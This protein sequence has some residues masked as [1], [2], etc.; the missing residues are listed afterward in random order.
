MNSPDTPTPDPW[1]N[2]RD[3]FLSAAALG[4][5]ILSS[6]KILHGFGRHLD[7]A[8]PRRGSLRIITVSGPLHHD[9]ECTHEPA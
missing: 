4:M 3:I 2:P 5:C 1:E 8:N 9:Q 7:R 6:A